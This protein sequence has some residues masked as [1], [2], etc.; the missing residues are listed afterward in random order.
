MIQHRNTAFTMGC[1]LSFLFLW[2]VI[3]KGF[4][5]L[6]KRDKKEFKLDERITY[7]TVHIEV[8]YSC[9]AWTPQSPRQLFPGDREGHQ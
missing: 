9:K 3:H 8:I 6:Y 1:V 2:L 7:S 4:T 5:L